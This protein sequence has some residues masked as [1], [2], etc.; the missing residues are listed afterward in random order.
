[1][2]FKLLNT[3]HRR[4]GKRVQIGL[5]SWAFVTSYQTKAARKM[6]GDLGYAV[7]VEL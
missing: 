6:I 4:D 7:A 3:P 2:S 5:N 1:M